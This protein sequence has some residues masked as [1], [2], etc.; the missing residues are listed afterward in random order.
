M[1]K[2]GGDRGR[3]LEGRK[4]TRKEGKM[5]IKEGRLS[6]KEGRKAGRTEVRKERRK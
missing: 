1:G 2:G 6:R 4:R 5:I 3:R